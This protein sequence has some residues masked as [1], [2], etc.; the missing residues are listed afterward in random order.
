VQIEGIGLSLIWYVV[1][2]WLLLKSR[3]SFSSARIT[4]LF[5]TKVIGTFALQWLFTYYYTD[6]ST[7]DI[8]RFFDDGLLLHK[9]FFS[10]PIDYIKIM[11]NAYSDGDGFKTLYFEQMNAWIKPNDSAFYNDNHFMIKVN[12][13]LTFLS[14]GHYE[15]HGIV[16]STLSF[17]GL[18]WCAESLTSEKKNQNLALTI[19]ILFPSSLLWM[20]GGLKETV[21]IFGIG[22]FIKVNPI[23][24][25]FNA[26]SLFLSLNALIVLISVKI[27]FI[28]ALVPAYLVHGLCRKRNWGLM[29]QFGLWSAFIITGYALASLAGFDLTE[30]IVRKQHDFLNHVQ[31]ISPGSAFEMSYLKE[32]VLAL[33]ASTPQAIANVLFRPYIYEVK[34]LPELLLFIENLFIAISL[35]LFTVHVIRFRDFS[36]LQIW[37]FLFVLPILILMGMVTPVFGAIMRYR[38]PA[39]I[40]LLIILTPYF[41][42]FL[43]GIKTT[44]Q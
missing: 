6:R 42:S 30:Y 32:G 7:A 29:L 26:K 14:F 27:Y 19:A 39:I 8:Y 36:K 43:T 21:L 22:A 20:S 15:V 13:L 11:F 34:T 16:F 33:L 38:A 37:I 2:L 28:A 25:Q 35:V 4:V 12:S 9:V 1:L 10:Q 18:K 23:H 17:L 31:V 5:T 40:L 24:L 41:R 3:G 44:N